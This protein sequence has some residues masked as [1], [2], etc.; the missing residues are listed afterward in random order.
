MLEN[1]GIP[2]KDPIIV[3]PETKNHWL[4]LEYHEQHTTVLFVE[5]NADEIAIMT[6]G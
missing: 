3:D 6:V 2:Y 4:A 1:F 5:M